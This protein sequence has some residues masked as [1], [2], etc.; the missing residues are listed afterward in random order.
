MDGPDGSHA[1]YFRRGGHW[2]RDTGAFALGKDAREHRIGVR[3][4]DDNKLHNAAIFITV[5]TAQPT[6]KP[7]K[8]GR[9]EANSGGHGRQKWGRGGAAAPVEGQLLGAHGRPRKVR[10]RMAVAG[11]SEERRVGEEGR[12]RWSP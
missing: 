6:R 3:L 10:I 5:G 8:P 11:R 1:R 7:T 9:M 12:S 2:R 4:N